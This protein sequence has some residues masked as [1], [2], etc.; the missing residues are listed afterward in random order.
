MVLP[1]TGVVRDA[2]TCIGRIVHL[3]H[4]S[5]IQRRY[6]HPLVRFRLYDMEFTA[7]MDDGEEMKCREG[8]VFLPIL[9]A[10][11]RLFSVHK[12][13]IGL[14]LRPNP[15][16]SF[17]RLG[18]AR[19]S[20]HWPKGTRRLD[21]AHT[22]HRWIRGATPDSELLRVLGTITPRLIVLI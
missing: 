19:T 12:R 1:S 4:L 22:S 20:H 3:P 7:L 6:V 14:V 11:E 2:L 17:S 18:N 13:V 15:D 8:L 9:E 21:R 5:H 10:S 16:G